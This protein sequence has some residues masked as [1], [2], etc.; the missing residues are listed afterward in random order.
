M[1]KIKFLGLTAL[2]IGFALAAETEMRAVDNHPLLLTHN[3]GE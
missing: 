3:Q 1:N 2:A